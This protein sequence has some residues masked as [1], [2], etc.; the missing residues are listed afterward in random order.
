MVI[1]D[2][3]NTLF[4]GCLHYSQ[5]GLVGIA[6]DNIGTL[7]DKGCCGFFGFRYVIKAAG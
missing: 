7:L 5:A 1:A 6:Q 3:H 2:S 4:L